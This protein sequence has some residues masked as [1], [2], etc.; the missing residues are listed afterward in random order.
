MTAE[1]DLDWKDIL[2]HATLFMFGWNSASPCVIFFRANL[3]RMSPH[4]FPRQCKSGSLLRI[5]TVEMSLPNQWCEGRGR[6][7]EREGPSARNVK[8]FSTIFMHRVEAH[9]PRGCTNTRQSP[10]LICSQSKCLVSLGFLN[11]L[12]HS[13]EVLSTWINTAHLWKQNPGHLS[14]LLD[15]KKYAVLE[16]ACPAAW[17]CCS[18]HSNAGKMQPPVRSCVWRDGDGKRREAGPVESSR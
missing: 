14:E 7:L 16:A 18:R 13:W 9:C 2:G 11:K 8:I 6:W 4:Y 1:Q 17:W 12:I 3:S 5:S 15:C 10:R